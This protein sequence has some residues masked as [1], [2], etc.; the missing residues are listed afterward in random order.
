MATIDMESVECVSSSD[1]IEEEEIQSSISSNLHS[2]HHGHPNQFPSKP[3]GLVPSAI[4]PTSVH[5]LLECPVCTNS[6][7]PPIHQVCCYY[8][9][10]IILSISLAFLIHSCIVLFGAEGGEIR[11]MVVFVDAM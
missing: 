5:E 1:G 9:F 2:I 11:Y 4:G 10:V 3:N 7:Y 6:M 8:P